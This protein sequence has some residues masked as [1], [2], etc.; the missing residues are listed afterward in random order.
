MGDDS[1]S[2][3]DQVLRGK[4]KIFDVEKSIYT[5]NQKV[6]N[7]P[8][9]FAQYISDGLRQGDVPENLRKLYKEAAYGSNER[10]KSR[11]ITRVY[12]VGRL[13]R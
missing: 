3:W 2:E 1:I 9:M 11:I 13:V 7:G 6:C 4:Y 12:S 8:L 5:D 10:V